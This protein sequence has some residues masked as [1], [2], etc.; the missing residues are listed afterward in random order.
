MIY[1]EAEFFDMLPR[2][3]SIKGKRMDFIKVNVF[4]SVNDTVQ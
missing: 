3:R 1:G 2:A 4:C